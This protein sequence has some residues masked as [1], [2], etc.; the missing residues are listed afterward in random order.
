MGKHISQQVMEAIETAI[1]TLSSTFSGFAF[2][3]LERDTILETMGLDDNADKLYLS[4]FFLPKQPVEEI[5]CYAQDI[6]VIIEILCQNVVDE[7]FKS[8][9][10]GNTVRQKLLLG[11]RAI[12]DLFRDN[13]IWGG[14][15]YSTFP[16]PID[17]E[18]QTMTTDKGELM[19]PAATL[20]FRVNVQWA[21]NDDESAF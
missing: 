17:G 10:T 16:I 15:A 7:N 8:G 20:S 9:V 13:D 2:T 6:E 21:F 14:L 3:K 5:G 19:K 12:S 1:K 4:C 18:G 11:T